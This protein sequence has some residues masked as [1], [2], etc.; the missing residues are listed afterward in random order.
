[1]SIGFL[2]DDDT[3]MV[4]RGPMVTQALEQLLQRHPLARTRLPDRRSAAGHRRHPADAGAE[5][6]GNRRRHR[7]HAAGHRAD[8]CAQGPEDVRKGRRSHR[9]HRREHGHPY[10]LAMRPRR[11]H[12]RRRRRGAHVP[13][14]QRSVP[15]SLPLDI[16]IREHADSG[17]PTVVADPDGPV[18]QIYKEIARKTARVHGAKSRGHRRPSF[19]IS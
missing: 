6:S 15:G 14:L 16:R 17:R 11:A 13:R 10:L 4:W 2:I 9:R 3:P 7:H 19:R 12:F 8:R 18:A 5:G 1:M